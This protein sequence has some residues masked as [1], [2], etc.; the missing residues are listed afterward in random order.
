MHTVALQLSHQGRQQNDTS[1]TQTYDKAGMGARTTPLPCSSILASLTTSQQLA[2]ETGRSSCSHDTD[3]AEKKGQRD[4]V[5][6]H[7]VSSIY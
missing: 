7:L 5:W 3:A 2:F 1:L 4:V 6:M